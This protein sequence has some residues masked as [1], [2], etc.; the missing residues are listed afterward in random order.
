M[1][2][3]HQPPPTG[4]VGAWSLPSQWQQELAKSGEL[5]VMAFAAQSTS[6]PPELV[7][8]RRT[9]LDAGRA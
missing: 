3:K 9:A 4:A 1:R 6:P 8:L 7:R 5:T 2:E